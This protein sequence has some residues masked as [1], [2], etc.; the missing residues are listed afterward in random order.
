M[1][2]QYDTHK[3]Y[4]NNL[5]EEYF[6][7]IELDFFSN[8]IYRRITIFFRF[9][10]KNMELPQHQQQQQQQQQI[11]PDS[12][13]TQLDP[14]TVIPD[15]TFVCDYAICQYFGERLDKDDVDTLNMITVIVII[16]I[17][18]VIA[19]TSLQCYCLCP[20]R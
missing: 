13:I 9:T 5:F 8:L 16:I 20:R 11:L 12:E 2:E 14:G 4:Y 6:S 10:A 1:H 3:N 18:L 7:R 19:V 15:T 17:I